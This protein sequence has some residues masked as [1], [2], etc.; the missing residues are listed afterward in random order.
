[1]KQIFTAAILL[2]AAALAQAQPVIKA[3]GVVN[4]A[5]YAAP[6]MPNGGIAQGSLFAV[7]GTGLGGAALQQVTAYPLT[8]TFAGTS[9]SVTVNGV[10]TKPF[11][12][13]TTAGQVGAL[14]PSTTPAGTGTV[15]LTYNGQ[16]SAPQ[17]I[18]VVASS[19]GIFTTNAQG[20]GL[21]SITSQGFVSASSTYAANPGEAFIIFG[22]GV[23]P[24]TGDES[25]PGSGLKLGTLPVEVLVGGKSVQVYAY[26]RAPQYSG[27][28]QVAFAV[29]SDVTGCAVPVAV[30]IGAVTSNFVTLPIAASG[31]TCS[32][33]VTNPPVVVGPGGTISVGSVDL[34]R[35]A[36]SI[37]VPG[38]GSSNFSADSGTGL[39]ARSTTANYNATPNPLLIST[40]GSCTVFTFKGAAPST[41]VPDS[42]LLDA[43][44]SL[45]VNG[46]G[47]QKSIPK[48]QGIYSA[49]FAMSSSIPGVPSTPLYLTK[50][51]YTVTGPGGADVGPFTA[52]LNVPDPLIWTNSSGIKTVN[53]A[54]GQLITWSSGDTNGNVYII[55]FSLTGTTV[56]NL[57]GA[58]F[59]C[60]ERNS[61]GKFT[62]PSS[63]LQALPATTTS[64]KAVSL[65]GAL[66]VEG[67]TVGTFKPS[68]LDQATISSSSLTVNSVNYQ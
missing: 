57:S 66:I 59:I 56:D 52:S 3:G 38:Y 1:M 28:D 25:G 4:A 17:A 65:L 44:P 27:L 30:R 50:G 34:S 23:G 53:R 24:T 54:A 37:D 58:E 20:T 18:Q 63:V 31:R 5:S 62:I 6:G 42:V 35:T 67:I 45:S 64:L 48:S 41:A 10:T 8:T 16:T 61:A 29:P 68:G 12:T 32:D 33:P 14:M 22:T 43:G 55:G 9:M 13:Y 51:T 21:G 36:G 2:C 39:F 46:P 49:Q 47:G 60:I 26:A 7:F 11:I 19:F 40:Y 15:T